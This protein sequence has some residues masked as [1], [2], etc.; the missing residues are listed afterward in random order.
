M[1]L[2]YTSFFFLLIIFLNGCSSFNLKSLNKDQVYKLL[3]T[4]AS[5]TIGIGLGLCDKKKRF[6]IA[7]EKYYFYALDSL[8]INKEK[9]SVYYYQY[10]LKHY[11]GINVTIDDITV[12]LN[13]NGKELIALADYSPKNIIR[14]IDFEG[15]TELFDENIIDFSLIV[16]YSIF[17]EGNLKNNSVHEIIMKENQTYKII[18][19]DNKIASAN[20][21]YK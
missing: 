19:E 10:L 14:I 16:D 5:Q 11:D 21:F 17:I 4:P 1:K 9:D 20:L 15:D 8:G 18:G 13:A 3:L 2:K 12:T 7:G 6:F